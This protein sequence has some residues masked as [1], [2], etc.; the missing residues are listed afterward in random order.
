MFKP[1][2]LR[3]RK[4]I[5]LREVMGGECQ[6]ELVKISRGREVLEVVRGIHPQ[7]DRNDVQKWKEK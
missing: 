4:W 6:E 2:R 1:L 5:S 7:L 3:R